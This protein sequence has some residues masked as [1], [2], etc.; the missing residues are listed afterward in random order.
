[1]SLFLSTHC[2]VFHDCYL[3]IQTGYKF[4]STRAKWYCMF[5]IINFMG[6][7]EAEVPN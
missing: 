2:F 4:G 5:S 1:M 3:K 7:F 6:K